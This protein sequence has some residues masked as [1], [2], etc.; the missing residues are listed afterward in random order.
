MSNEGKTCGTCARHD[1]GCAYCSLWGRRTKKGET[2]P[3]WSDGK[4][5]RTADKTIGENDTKGGKR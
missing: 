4:A 2:C 5:E 3:E 1:H